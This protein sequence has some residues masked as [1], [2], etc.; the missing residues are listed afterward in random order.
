MGYD[1]SA[2]KRPV[3]MSLNEDLIRQAR[4][5]IPNLS[6]TVETLLADHVQ[7]LQ[8]G[9]SLRKK[10]IAAVVAAENAFVAEFGSFSDE[11][12]GL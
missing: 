12:N 8:D 4:E 10:Q 5:I 11:Y 7:G 9:A 2:P 1:P 3:N 6:V